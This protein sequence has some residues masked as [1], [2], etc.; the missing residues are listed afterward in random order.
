MRQ[1]EAANKE[2]LICN[3]CNKIYFSIIGLNGHMRTQFQYSTILSVVQD[4]TFLR[5]M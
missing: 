1:V 4:M 2:I 3:V 5:I